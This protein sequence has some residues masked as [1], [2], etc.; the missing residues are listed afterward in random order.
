MR[1]RDFIGAIAGSAAAWPPAVRAQ[2]PTIPVI[3]FLSSTSL[4]PVAHHLTAFRQGL[5]ETG[6]SEG[7]NVTIEYRWADGKFDQLPA[8]AI[9]L[10]HRRVAV[11]VTFGGEPAALAAKAATSTIPIV[12]GIGG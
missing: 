2:Q 10:V 9:D 7:R 11:I 12:F 1:R 6:Y 3:G 4:A 5:S 8:F